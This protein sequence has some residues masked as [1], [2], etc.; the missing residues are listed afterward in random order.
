MVPPYSAEELIRRS[1]NDYIRLTNATV[2]FHTTDDNKDHDTAVFVQV[3]SKKDGRLLAHIENA[4]SSNYDSTEYQDDSTHS[5]SLAFGQV[6]KSDCEETQ[7][8][9]G[10]HATGHDDWM[11]DVAVTLYFIDGTTIVRTSKYTRELISWDEYVT[12]DM[13]GP[14][15]TH[16]TTPPPN[17]YRFGLIHPPTQPSNAPEYG[18]NWYGGGSSVHLPPP[19]IAKI[20]GVQNI[21]DYIIH[22]W[23]RDD[24]GKVKYGNPPL[25]LIPGEYTLEFNQMNASGDWRAIGP[26]YDPQ[27]M[28]SLSMLI[29]WEEV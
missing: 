24:D 12:T 16:T 6:K 9:I 18:M 21:S 27:K 11:F 23:Y 28:Q 3:V 1:L 29:W 13:D 20:T 17:P 5:L 26:P 25:T 4:D 22:L 2:T 7:I 8:T 10:S 14:P 15:I 19:H